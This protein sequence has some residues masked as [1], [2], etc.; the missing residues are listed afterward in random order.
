MMLEVHI[1]AYEVFFSVEVNLCRC[2]FI[3][4]LYMYYHWRSS[5]QGSDSI[6]R[7]NPDKFV[8][9]SKAKI[10]TSNIICGYLPFLSTIAGSMNAMCICFLNKITICKTKWQSWSYCSWIYNYLCNPYLL[11]LKMWFRIQLMVWC[12][13]CNIM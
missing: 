8:C 4:C 11:L 1:L 2:F 9:L 5:Y 7:F 6:N 10:W 12:I 13:G 3:I